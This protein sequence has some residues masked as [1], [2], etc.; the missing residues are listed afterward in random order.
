MQRLLEKMPRIRPTRE[1]YLYDYDRWDY[2]NDDKNSIDIDTNFIV[3]LAFESQDEETAAIV[4]KHLQSD[5]KQ[6]LKID[7][8]ITHRN[9]RILFSVISL[10]EN[11]W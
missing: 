10:C 3:D 11:N 8:R 1:H 2:T 5:D 4:N 9:Q 7:G 6:D